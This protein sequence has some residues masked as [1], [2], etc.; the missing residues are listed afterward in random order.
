MIGAVLFPKAGTPRGRS[1]FAAAFLSL[2]FPGLGH[3]YAGA[4][5]RAL[6]FA[7][8][9]ILLAALL[10]GIVLRVDR[11]ELVGFLLVPWVLPSIFVLNLIALL[12]RLIA[13]ID[14]YRVT[15]YLNAWTASGGGRLGRPRIPVQPLSVAGLLAVLLVMAFGHV[16]LARYDV[17]AINTADCI[18]DPDQD[19]TSSESPGATVDTTESPTPDVSISL[20]PEGSALPNE[21][22]PPWNGKDRLNIL[23]IGA[24]EQ[25]GGHNT[26]TLIV[27]SIDPISKQVAM[28][29]LPRDMVDIPLPPGPARSIMG[30]TYP[31]K[32]NSLF[33]RVRNRAD[34]FPGTSRTRGYNALKSVLGNLYGLDVKYFVE[35]NFN[36]FIK[37]VN[38]LGGVTINVQS[39]LIDEDYPGPHGR[40]RIYIPSGVQHMTG[41]QALIYARSRHGKFGRGSS[42]YDRGQRQQ[43]ILLSLREQLNISTVLPRIN[44][45]ASAM[46]QAVRTDIPRDLLPQLLGLADSI[47]TKTIR[48]YVFAPP[49][50]GQEGSRNGLGFVIEPSVARIR[51]AVKQ[52]FIIDPALEATREAVADEGAKVWVLNGAGSAGQAARI[53][54]Y[55]EYQ[56]LTVSAPATRPSQPAGSGTRIVVYNG[57]EG[58]LPA[59]VKLLQQV[60]NTTIVPVTD[61]TA[62]VDIVITVGRSTPE[63]TPPPA[64]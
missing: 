30:A 9:P 7:A 6:A 64:P 43:R 38:A 50:Y 34:L 53:A 22:A 29:S 61:P 10:A 33:V 49:R 1:P 12:Y 24:D 28:F 52:A 3:A 60:F 37:V 59:T 26:D 32:I 35:V 48:S 25:E 15:A 63:L 27:V 54:A 13:I 4:H 58:R 19:C 8:T 31:S 18:F 11:G 16:A 36:G 56:G 23:L 17:I 5:Q 57:A 2:L 46:S 47:D 39:P 21:T 42:D 40:L 62:T 41:E 55:L 44:D 51:T 20:P 14:A 45:L